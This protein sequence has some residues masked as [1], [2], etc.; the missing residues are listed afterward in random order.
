LSRHDDERR[1]DASRKREER[2]AGRVVV[3][4]P[5]KNKAR[6]KRLEKDVFKWLRWYGADEFT[7]DFTE[8]QRR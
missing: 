4:P 2:R 6:R 7:R 5:C 3:I 1:R 8:Q